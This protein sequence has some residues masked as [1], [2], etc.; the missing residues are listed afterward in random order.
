MA[1]F[2]EHYSIIKKLGLLELWEPNTLK[3]HPIRS[4]A[5]QDYLAKKDVLSNASEGTFNLEPFFLR[6]I[7][8]NVEAD[9]ELNLVS[10]GFK[11]EKLEER[12]E[13]LRQIFDPLVAL[14]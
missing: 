11:K 3:H 12:E 8:K 6:E 1:E 14:A 7:I 9:P 10:T 2:K 5:E 4:W 13:K